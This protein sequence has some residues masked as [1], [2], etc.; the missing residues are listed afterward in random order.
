LHGANASAS[1]RRTRVTED[2][3][4]GTADNSANAYTFCDLTT[5][6]YLSGIGLTV[7]VIVCVLFHISTTAIN[8]D[9]VA[10][11]RG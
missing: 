6:V 8:N 7:C 4:D 5:P 10:G 3:T 1:G 2:S 9:L 11:A